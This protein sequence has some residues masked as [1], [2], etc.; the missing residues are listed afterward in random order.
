MNVPTRRIFLLSPASCSGRRAQILLSGRATFDLAQSIRTEKGAPLAD[1]FSFLSGLYFRG[2]I[3]YA[4]KFARIAANH[5]GIFVIT[6]GRG[7]MAPDTPIR[8]SDLHEFAGVPIDVA[9]PRYREPLVRD[10]EAL[11]NQLSS[12]GQVILLG[13]V[14]TDKYVQILSVAL[15]ERLLFPQ[16][17]VGRGDM[18]RGGLMLRCVHQ[19]HELEYVPVLSTV[20]RGTRPAKLPKREY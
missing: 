1:V 12:D 8:I 11:S 14:A 10:V 15:G 9:E 17:F 2:K 20:R 4:R 6:A 7:L 13:S 5:P 18:S 3:T 19:E 16:E